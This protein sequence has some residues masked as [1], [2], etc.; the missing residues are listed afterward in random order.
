MLL[1][2]NCT[3]KILGGKNIQSH[4]YYFKKILDHSYI[5]N[6]KMNQSQTVLNFYTS[7]FCI[8]TSFIEKWMR[9]YC[10]TCQRHFT[11][12]GWKLKSLPTESLYKPFG[13]NNQKWQSNAT[14]LWV[15][16][17]VFFFFPSTFASTALLGWGL[18]STPQKDST[19]INRMNTRW[20]V[21][22]FNTHL[23]WVTDLKAG[24]P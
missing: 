7:F 17:S 10:Q 19:P 3:R 16:S 13:K 9:D 1:R 4:S 12:K 6:T 14:A 21:I 22:C 24:F 20:L 23:C 18:P 8:S 5:K 11:F 15:L 2:L